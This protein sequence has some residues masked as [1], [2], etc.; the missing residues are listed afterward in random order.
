MAPIRKG[1]GTPL[2]IPGVQEVRTGDGRVFFEGGAIPENVVDNFEDSNANPAGVYDAGETLADYYSG[3]I[4]EFSRE[5]NASIIGETGVESTGEFGYIIS[6][7]ED[8][9]NRYIQQGE[10]FNIFIRPNTTDAAPGILFGAQDLD[11][12]L[13]VRLQGFQSGME[14]FERVEGSFNDVESN[15]WEF[16][17][18]EV[19]RLEVDWKNGG[20]VDFKVFNNQESEEASL[21]WD[22]PDDLFAD[23]VGVGLYTNNGPAQYDEFIVVE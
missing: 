7:P 8:G 10:T 13:G 23:A 3:D 21:S 14:I 17:E 12:H 11:N 16:T 15:S 19:Y 9:L 2:E 5:S 22:N 6:T 4:E 18:G 1:D 20:E